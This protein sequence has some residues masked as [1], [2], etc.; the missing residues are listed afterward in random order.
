[1]TR[2]SLKF[3]CERDTILPA[4]YR[5]H[6]LLWYIDR[7]LQD[8]ACSNRLSR[9]CTQCRSLDG[10]QYCL[11]IYQINITTSKSFFLATLLVYP[12]VSALISPSLFLTIFCETSYF[13]N[14]YLLFLNT[15]FVHAYV[16]AS[17]LRY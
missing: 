8:N 5:R 10:I 14:R 1:M 6:K 7:A 16:A 15:H 13:Y 12:F 3:K 17:S 2:D 9:R 4:N 11:Y